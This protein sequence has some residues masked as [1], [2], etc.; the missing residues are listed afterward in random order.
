VGARADWPAHGRV[1]DRGDG[2]PAGPPAAPRTQH[3]VDH[4]LTPAPSPLRLLVPIMPRAGD[5]R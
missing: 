3:N 5:C 4:W 1:A 2:Q